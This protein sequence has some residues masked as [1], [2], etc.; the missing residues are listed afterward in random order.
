MKILDRYIIRQ[1]LINFVVLAFV[2]MM[3]FVLV[4]LIVDL[5]EFLAAGRKRA[6]LLL[7]AD[8]GA[9]GVLQLAAGIVWTVADYYGPM[10]L[11]VY[12]F[13]S[14]LLVTAA[15]GFTFTALARNREIIA[16]IGS[17]ISM[18]RI[19]APVVVV[20][21]GLNLLTLP[22][23]E[24]LIPPV[25]EKLAR[26]KSRIKQDA[27]E[28]FNF[29]F[30][31]DQNGNLLS[32]AKCDFQRRELTDVTIYFRDPAGRTLRR[33]GAKTADWDDAAKRWELHQA[34]ESRLDI[35]SSGVTFD[36]QAVDY[37]E[38]DLTPSAL[39]ARHRSIYPRLLSFSELQELRNDPAANAVQIMHSRFSLLIANALVLLMGLPFFMLREPAHML[40]QVIK[41]AGV[42]IGAWA[43]G[44]VM[45]QMNA[46]FLPPVAM[47]WLPVALY[48]PASA[49]F[50]QRVKS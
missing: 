13:L 32:A 17:G 5:D 25:K 34:H 47:A 1:F 3:L 48:L 49:F 8:G 42:C 18:Y 15:M 21:F 7:G 20:G 43:G 4:D 39:L 40:V 29:Q 23:Q 26:S 24:Y 14:G 50:L 27:V 37:Y 19:A 11:L 22:V 38:T 33:V 12:T 31:R 28:T 30:A 41:A 2:F 46:P 9:P 35:S 44:L 10:V 45:L 36:P 6:E 16:V